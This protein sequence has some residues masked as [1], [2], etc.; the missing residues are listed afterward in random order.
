M[1]YSDLLKVTVYTGALAVMAVVEIRGE[2]AARQTVPKSLWLNPAIFSSISMVTKPKAKNSQ[3]SLATRLRR[4]HGNC[5]MVLI[6]SM[7]PVK[8]Q[9]WDQVRFQA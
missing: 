4:F 3:R 6:G 7:P 9:Y 1:R 8:R 2:M 5:W